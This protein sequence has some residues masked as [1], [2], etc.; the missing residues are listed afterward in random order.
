MK[1]VIWSFIGSILVM[2]ATFFW[3]YYSTSKELTVSK[4]SHDIVI[5]PSTKID[6][7]SISYNKEE[8][9]NLSKTI[10]SIENTG[11]VSIK[12]NDVTSPFIFQV[13]GTT[14]VFDFILNGEDPVNL[15]VI[16]DRNK[17]TVTA[18]F[19]LLNQG[20]KFQI[21][22]LSDSLSA[23]SI[24]AEARIDGIKDIKIKNDN[25]ENSTW[26]NIFLWG[27]LSISLLFILVIILNLTEVKDQIRVNRLIKNKKLIIPDN[28]VNLDKWVQNIFTFYSRSEKAILTEA[29]TKAKDKKYEEKIKLIIHVTKGFSDTVAGILLLS[30]IAAGCLYFSLSGLNYL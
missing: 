1:A 5:S 21:S 11:R 12:K 4:V 29:L 28:T 25:N 18:D 2:L 6:G 23:P 9:T 26:Y 30:F 8:I 19:S 24:S 15:G 27:V 14:K 7:I 16:L 10:F 20:D 13:N 17:N 22:V 3:G